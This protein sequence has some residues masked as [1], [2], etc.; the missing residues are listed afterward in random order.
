MWLTAVVNHCNLAVTT[1]VAVT[2]AGLKCNFTQ[3]INP[4]TLITDFCFQ[5]NKKGT[6]AEDDSVFKGKVPAVPIKPKINKAIFQAGNQLL[7]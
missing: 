6:I 4:D 7:L 1:N 3:F 2:V 5:L